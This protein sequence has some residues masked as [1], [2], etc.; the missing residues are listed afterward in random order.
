MLPVLSNDQTRV[1]IEV[2][3]KALRRRF[4]TAHGAFR[5]LEKAGY[6]GDEGALFA[7]A[8]LLPILE[9]TIL[10]SKDYR[11][12]ERAIRMMEEVFFRR[13]RVAFEIELP[14]IGGALCEVSW[15]EI[16]KRAAASKARP[17]FANRSLV[18][19]VD[20][21]HVLVTKFMRPQDLLEDL[22]NEV[23]WMLYLKEHSF[24]KRFVIP[25]PVA[26]KGSYL[27]TVTGI[28]IDKAS[29]VALHPKRHAI[30]FTVHKDYFS[31]PN[32]PR[33]SERL[34]SEEIKEVMTR[35]AYLLGKLT[36]LGVIH[37][38][39]IA[40]FHT[41]V[42]AKRRLDAGTYCWWQG[43]VGRLDRWLDSC[44]WPNLGVSGIRDFEHF[45]SFRGSYEELI[46][47]IGNHL[48]GLFLVTGSYFRNKDRRS[49]GL[50]RNRRPVDTWYLFDR[51]LLRK[52]VEGIV[53]SYHEGLTGTRWPGEAFLFDF[54][55]LT[56]RMVAEMGSDHHMIE[57]L[58]SRH[59]REMSASAF[60]E[61]LRKGGYCEDEIDQLT[62]GEEDIDIVTGPHLGEFNGEISLP[63]MVDLIRKVAVLST[64]HLFD[65]L[66]PSLE[67]GLAR[68]KKEVLDP[69]MP[70]THGRKLPHLRPPLRSHAA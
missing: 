25:E 46:Q 55:L 32:S 70:V 2:S 58:R 37:T 16:L 45:V 35:C 18:L 14:T 64:M 57:T 43:C 3:A 1:V 68:E 24:Q 61:I 10:Q 13:Q 56:E 31:Y 60:R 53:C 41:R 23:K 52:I 29:H 19:E 49:V 39:I 44:D 33:P 36:S 47:H 63:E 7:I 5:A 8:E 69:T 4:F 48:L 30:C 62:Q 20:H 6:W 51:A 38:D 66:G 26:F 15:K 21:D 42:Q 11:L 28:P 27:F 17:R 9:E 65:R 22:S 59:Q 54:E 34:S 12:R 50:D 40:L 67:K